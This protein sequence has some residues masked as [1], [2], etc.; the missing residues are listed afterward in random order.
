MLAASAWF[1]LA[2]LWIV[3]SR[4]GYP[5]A[6]EWMEGGT[7]GHVARVLAGR[8]IY[9]PPS[10]EFTPYM[11]TPLFNWIAAPVVG[12][13]GV[14]LPSVRVVS[15][16][17]AFG[18]FVVVHRLI[19][20]TTS[21]AFAAW[22]GLGV[23]AASF[24]VGG[25]W[26]DLARIDSMFLFFLSA[27]LLLLVTGERQDLLAGVLLALAFLTKQTAVMVAAP[28]CAARVVTL[29]GHRRWHCGLAFAAV[30][31]ASTL[32]LD[33]ATSG[34]YLYYVFELPQGHRFVRSMFVDFWTQDLRLLAP[35]GLA[36]LYVLARR[37]DWRPRVTRLA[38][39]VGLLGA[40]WLSRINT[41]GAANCLWPALILFAWLS[42]EAV[43]L[44]R[45]QLPPES[46]RRLAVCGLCLLQLGLL[47]YDPRLQI[48]RPEERR[49]NDELVE[50]LR[51]YPGPVLVPHHS[52]LP[53][54]AGKPG[55]AHEMA[56]WDVLNVGG[57][58]GRDLLAAEIRAALGAGRFDAIVTD[59]PWLRREPKPLY[60]R[61]PLRRANGERY[62][63]TLLGWRTGPTL[64]LERARASGSTAP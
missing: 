32:W 9:G 14:G 46:A 8:P 52:E 40:A 22:C 55:H 28:L 56:I 31:G 11:Y 24:V 15:I 39:A 61:R 64:L 58:R 5:Y 54:L 30:V 50:L 47:L 59:G 60:E 38:A 16:L 18:L 49:A 4:V 51:G 20:R 17:A 37:Q 25:G 33:R 44:G 57:R 2:L 34:W 13:L 21:D 7:L 41:G 12:W 48:P 3:A 43:A 63:Q 10:L 36:A 1:L 45:A 35:S 27:A 53:L 62:P 29:S 23:L 19:R 42:G 6:L 26:L